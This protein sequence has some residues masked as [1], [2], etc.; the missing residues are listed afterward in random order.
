AYLGNEVTT[1]YPLTDDAIKITA[2]LLGDGSLSGGNIGFTQAEG[3]ALDEV[4]TSSKALGC[5]LKHLR[6]Y[7]YRITKP[8]GRYG[9]KQHFIRQLMIDCGLF[10]KDSYEKQFPDWAWLL[11]NRQLSL[12]L[13][14]LLAC[15]GWAHSNTRKDGKVNKEVGFATVSEQLARD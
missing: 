8:G 4:K 14:R 9:K 10:G 15:D 6:G 12:F 11:D 5:E 13:S 1:P 3:P 7:D 2:Y